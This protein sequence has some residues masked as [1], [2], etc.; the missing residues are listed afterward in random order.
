M[1]NVLHLIPFADWCDECQELLRLREKE[2]LL[3][4]NSATICV[5][6]VQEPKSEEA[7]GQEDLEGHGQDDTTDDQFTDVW[8]IPGVI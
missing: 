6:K 7:A 2:L 3:T 1:K 4:Y 5:R 8:T